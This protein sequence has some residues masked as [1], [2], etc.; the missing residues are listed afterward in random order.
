M[1]EWSD[2]LFLQ[3]RTTGNR[4]LP[5]YSHQQIII[6]GNSDCFFSVC[7]VVATNTTFISLIKFNG[8]IRRLLFVGFFFP[9][10]GVWRKKKAGYRILCVLCRTQE[11]SFYSTFVMKTLYFCLNLCQH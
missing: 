6:S 8:T 9:L 11:Y 5:V 10:L 1:I 4:T 2:H 3:K 7:V